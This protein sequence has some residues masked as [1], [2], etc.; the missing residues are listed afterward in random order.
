MHPKCSSGKL[1]GFTIN[2][3]QAVEYGV[4]ITQQAKKFLSFSLLCIRT[5]RGS[6]VHE[7]FKY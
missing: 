1:L 4:T 3:V 2:I 5:K 7:Q 6:L